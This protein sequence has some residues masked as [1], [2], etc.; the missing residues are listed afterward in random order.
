M[1]G[2]SGRHV[3][4]RVGLR[5]GLG[6]VLACPLALSFPVL[7]AA[8]PRSV[9][10]QAAAGQPGMAPR[11]T[12]QRVAD[13][14]AANDLAEAETTVAAALRTYPSDPSLHNLA[15]VVAAQQGTF[16]AAESHFQTAIRLAPGAASPYENLGRLYLERTAVEPDARTKALETYRQLLGIDPSNVEGL[17]QSALL[18][19]IDGRFAESRGLIAKL[20]E[21]LGARPQATAVLVAD[22]AGLG[23]HEAGMTTVSRLA[24]HPDLTAADILGVLPALDRAKDETLVQALFEAV[25]A[26]GLAT[27]AVLHR[28]GLIH[29][30]S[31]RLDAA[32]QVLDRAASA[33]PSA[34]LLLDLARI[35]N[36]LEDRKGALGYLAHA[37]AIDPAN[38]DVHFLF[39]MICVELDLGAEA[40]ESLKQAV[41]LEPDSALVNYALGAVSIHRHEPSE[42]IPYFEKYVALKPDDPRG[43]FALGAARFHANQ[44]DKARAD[45]ERAARTPETAAGAHYFLARIARQFNDLDTARQEIERSLEANPKYADAWAELGLVQMRTGSHEEAQQSL[46]KALA[47]DPDNYAATVNLA[48]LYSRTKDPRREQQAERLAALQEKRAVEAQE[49]LRIIEV[50]P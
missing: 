30:R 32:R 3:V 42:A 31:G 35:A 16:A 19:A 47:L 9:E 2:A 26:R 22:L 13:L 38:A 20:P 40:Y 17:Y 18:L 6:V 34:A 8:A 28:L 12:L 7:L 5:V 50:V 10:R 14:I 46:D 37:R 25:D 1:S 33:E 29:A 49:F 39:G 27:P 36:R 44:F 21:E 15:G 24:S 41:A 48:T 23:D 11:D 45:L 43:R 4:L